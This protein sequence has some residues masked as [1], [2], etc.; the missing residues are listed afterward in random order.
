MLTNQLGTNKYAFDKNIYIVNVAVQS[1][2]LCY[3]YY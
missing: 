1:L 2:D 3:K